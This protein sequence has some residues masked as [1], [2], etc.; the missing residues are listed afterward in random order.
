MSNKR[1]R[2]VTLVELIVAMVIVGVAVGGM[3]AAFNSS[4]ASSV[5]PMLSKQ[6]A[7]VAESM[8]EEILLKPYSGTDAANR[9]DFTN[10]SNYK[11]Y[12]STGVFDATGNA[13]SGL[14]KYDVAVAI[15]AVQLTGM[16]NQDALRIEVT[17]K[18]GGDNFILRGWR[19]QP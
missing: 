6:M 3:I 4:T 2:G 12:H 16:A 13:V 18:H 7:A 14:E 17:V 9:A 1:Q 8:M 5:D 11:G 15:D 10:V 19:T